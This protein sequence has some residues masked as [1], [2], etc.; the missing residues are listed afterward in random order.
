MLEFDAAGVVS[1][2]EGELVDVSPELVEVDTA[3]PTPTQ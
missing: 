2:V 3:A 1:A